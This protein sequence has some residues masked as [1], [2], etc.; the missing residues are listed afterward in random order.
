MGKLRPGGGR[1]PSLK[2]TQRVGVGR[3]LGLRL[4][5]LPG[6]RT[7]GTDVWTG[8]WAE[9]WLRGRRLQAQGLNPSLPLRSAT[10]ATAPPAAPAGEGGPPGPPPNLTSNRRLQQT[11]AQV[12]EVSWVWVGA[13]K[14]SRKDTE[15][16][17]TSAGVHHGLGVMVVHVYE[18]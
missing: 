7:G 18:F 10:A 8:E 17:Q 2:V 11:Q 1:G 5:G 6:R 9:S 4:G 12:D 13:A 3:N 14:D 15:G 16:W